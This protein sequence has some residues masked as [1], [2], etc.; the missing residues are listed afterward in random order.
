MESQ[1]GG[2][3][4]IAL[5]IFGLV[6]LVCWIV[7]P[8]ALIGTKAILRELVREQRRTNALLEAA[9]RDRAERP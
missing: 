4:Y 5:F 8:F 1:V 6:L 7:L 3:L 2:V 9:A